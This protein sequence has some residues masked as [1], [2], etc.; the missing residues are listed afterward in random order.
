MVETSPLSL[1]ESGKVAMIYG[2]SWRQI[3][4]SNN[5]FIKD[6]VDVAAL[7]KGKQQAVI[8]HGLGN[9][10]GANTAH[11]EEAWEFLKFLG[12][13]QA[14]EIQARTGAV[15]PAFTGAQEIWVQSNPQFNLQVFLDQLPNAVPYPV[16]ENTGEWQALE[17]E[18]FAK[19]WS[20]QASTEDAAKQA[21]Q[22]M[23]QILQQDQ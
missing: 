17:K 21:A 6:K 18:H 5:E 16:S 3:Q 23:N 13:Q 7:P 11:P 2:G 8:I 22:Q 15:I 1:F 12:G 20:G 10:I 19:A 4:F 9:V 14:A